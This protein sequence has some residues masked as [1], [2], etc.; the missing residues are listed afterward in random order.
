MKNVD[1]SGW[2]LLCMTSLSFVN[3]EFKMF[4]NIKGVFNDY[5]KAFPEKASN[6]DCCMK[7]GKFKLIFG[8][9]SA[10]VK[11]KDFVNGDACYLGCIKSGN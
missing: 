3:Q 2:Y 11:M 10:L 4:S 5:I 7:F 9:V 8:E 1:I 6:H